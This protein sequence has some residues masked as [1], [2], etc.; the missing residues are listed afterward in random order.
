MEF[1]VCRKAGKPRCLSIG[2]W[3]FYIGISTRNESITSIFENQLK[4]HEIIHTSF[5]GNA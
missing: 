2:I 4:S 5:I 1:P 3:N